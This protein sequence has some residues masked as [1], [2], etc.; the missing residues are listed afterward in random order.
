MYSNAR[1]LLT[2]VLKVL[3]LNLTKT[4]ALVLK[5]H[6]LRL[7]LLPLPPLPTVFAVGIR[8]SSSTMQSIILWT[9]LFGQRKRQGVAQL[10]E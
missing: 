6:T 10:M 2:S 1:R 9:M 3:R 4:R 5:S 8:A 7:Q